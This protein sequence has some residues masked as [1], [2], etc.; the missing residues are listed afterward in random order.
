MTNG[1]AREMQSDARWVWYGGRPSLDL[2]NTRRNREAAPVEYLGQPADLADWLRAAALVTAAR[3]DP[4]AS[5]PP[6]GAL[7]AD[8][9][10][11]ADDALLADARELREAIDAGI[12]AA[13]TGQPFP[14]AA[15]VELNRWLAAAP[16][17]PPELQMSGAVAI[18]R[19]RPSLR[20]PRQALTDIALDAAELLG[21]GL[22]EKLRIC[23]GPGCA[24]RFVDDSPA[25]RR[26]WCSMAVCGNRSKA[27]THRHAD[28]V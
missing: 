17:Q 12:R 28:R 14:P 18:L 4:D 26:R 7:L 25:G 24:G 27:A 22:R 9:S 21:T 5:P 11:L 20:Q 16:T 6:D 2:V 10:L 1:E 15:L 23:P 8:A 13:V 3:F 19:T